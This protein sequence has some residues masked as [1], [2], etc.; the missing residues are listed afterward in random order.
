MA[1]LTSWEYIPRE[2]HKDEGDQAERGQGKVNRGVWWNSL[3]RLS[4]SVQLLMSL[5]HSAMHSIVGFCCIDFAREDMV[6]VQA[7]LISGDIRSHRPKVSGLSTP[8]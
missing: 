2:I 5:V 6:S 7:I 3:A 1:M 4:I 8:R